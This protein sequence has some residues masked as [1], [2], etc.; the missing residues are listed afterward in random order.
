MSDFLNNKYILVV[1]DDPTMQM[2]LQGMIDKA[3]FKPVIAE[4]GAKALQFLEIGGANIGLVLLDRHLPDMDGF[5]VVQKIKDIEASASIPII[6]QS[7]SNKPKDIRDAIDAGIFYYLTKP[8]KIEALQNVL[9]LAIGAS[10]RRSILRERF[11]S[12]YTPINL[13]RSASFEF[14]TMEEG[15]KMAILLSCFFPDPSR[16]Y[17]GVTA[18]LNNALE[19]GS[20]G[21]GYEEKTKLLDAEG[22]AECIDVMQAKKAHKDKLVEV[23]FVH[24][25]GRFSVRVTDSGKGFDWKSWMD[26]DADLGSYSHGYGVLKALKAFDEVKYN[27]AGNQVMASVFDK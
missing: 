26:F 4:N 7:G 5:E 22:Y 10:E 3:G 21:V 14:H 11:S 27:T 19:H 17:P 25:D 15:Q 20:L 8:F 23:Q 13:I 16:V 24:K 6:M 1:D 18:L 9:N 12:G 2:V